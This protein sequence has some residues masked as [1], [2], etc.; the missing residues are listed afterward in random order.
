M[1]GDRFNY[2]LLGR[3]QQDCEYYLNHG[4]R[5]PKHLWA[6]DEAEQIAKMREIFDALAVKPE[7]ITRDDITRYEL[8]MLITK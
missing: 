3:L 2:Q 8:A 6:G 5:S 1:T 7:W 4:N